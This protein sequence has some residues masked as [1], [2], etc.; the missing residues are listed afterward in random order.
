MSFT[1]SVAEAVKYGDASGRNPN[2]ETFCKVSVG[3]NA[4]EERISSL[5]NVQNETRNGMWLEVVISFVR[6]YSGLRRKKKSSVTG[7]HFIS[8]S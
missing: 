2:R 5:N 3:Q 7:M 1:S 6:I 4:E 8:L